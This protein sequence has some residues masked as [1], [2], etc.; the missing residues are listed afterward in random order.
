[1]TGHAGNC[2]GYQ[3]PATSCG[4]AQVIFLLSSTDKN[5]RLRGAKH[6]PLF[7][8]RSRKVK[9]GN[10]TL[11][12][13]RAVGCFAEVIQFLRCSGCTFERPKVLPEDCRR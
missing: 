1:M 7:F 3:I 10:G 5:A 4:E 8:F 9:C 13:K 11:K 6:G 2:P 12:V